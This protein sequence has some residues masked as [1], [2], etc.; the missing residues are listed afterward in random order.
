MCLPTHIW[1]FV[2]CPFWKWGS[3]GSWPVMDPVAWSF[4]WWDI[5]SVLLVLSTSHVPL[6]SYSF[7]WGFGKWNILR[8]NPTTSLKIKAHSNLA[9][10][11][12]FSFFSLGLDYLSKTQKI[13]V[14]NWC[15]LA[16]LCWTR[17]STSE[18]QF[19]DESLMNDSQTSSNTL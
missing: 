5:R 19:L 12:F 13:Q 18:L 16:E 1:R 4:L 10:L 11:Y 8:L 2:G 17:H 3:S 7:L 6:T 15:Y 14:Q 9:L